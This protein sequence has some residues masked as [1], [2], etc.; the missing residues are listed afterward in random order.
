MNLIINY[1]YR[2]NHKPSLQQAIAGRGL[3]GILIDDGNLL[4][5]FTDAAMVID[6]SKRTFAFRRVLADWIIF[7]GWLRITRVIEDQ[8]Q[9]ILEVSGALFT[10]RIV[11][12]RA[13][14]DWKIVLQG[15]R[16]LGSA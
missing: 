10:S 7:P 5:R 3:T 12:R 9:I 8:N 14:G 2:D 13:D 11:V 6:L 15:G 16:I 1:L 4:L